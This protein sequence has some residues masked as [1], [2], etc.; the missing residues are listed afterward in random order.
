M[1]YLRLPTAILVRG[2]PQ[3]QDTTDATPITAE[4]WDRT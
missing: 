1:W 4:C 3:E 2:P